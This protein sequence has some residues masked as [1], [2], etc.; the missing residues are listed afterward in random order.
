[1][2]CILPSHLGQANTSIKKTRSSSVAHGTR[3][4]DVM[5]WIPRQSSFAHTR[6]SQKPSSSLLIHFFDIPFIPVEN[7]IEQG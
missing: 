5:G 2:R 6:T 3:P 4:L 7:L 1:M